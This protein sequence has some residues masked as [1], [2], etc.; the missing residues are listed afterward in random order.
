MG[1]YTSYN[2]SMIEGD[3]KLINEFRDFSENA[4]YAIDE[5]GECQDSCKWYTSNEELIKFSKT[6]PDAIFML[7]GEGEENGDAWRL[8]VKDG[9]SQECRAEMIY[10]EFDRGKLL[11]EI[12]DKKID[13]VLK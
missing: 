10:P 12:R 5:D 1:Y 8:Y 11:S 6:K 2:L 4:K 7:S 3:E 13:N 9:H